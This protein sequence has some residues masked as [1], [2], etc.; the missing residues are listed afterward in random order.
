MRNVLAE[1][2]PRNDLLSE[3]KAAWARVAKVTGYIIAV[4]F[5]VQSVLYLLDVTGVLAAPIDYRVSSLGMQ[6]DLIIYY[7][8]L[9]ERM[10]SIWWSV[11]VR[12]TVGPLGY[13]SLIVLVLAISHVTRRGRP[14]VELALLFT[15]VGASTAAASD[16]IFLSQIGSWRYGFQ[17]TPD[18]VSFG[19]A[20]EILDNVVDYLQ[21][22]AFIVLA[23]AFVC[24]GGLI[25]SQR[26]SHRR[27]AQVFAYLEATALV[28]YV[29]ADLARWNTGQAVAA[30]MAGIVLGPTWAILVGHFLT[31]HG[32]P[33]VLGQ[34]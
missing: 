2:G 31:H 17:P 27:A 11:A 19:R 9:N 16:L 33:A 32:T 1:N 28:A 20:S 26:T 4:A 34:E 15:V 12:D 10:H 29:L 8:A 14:R 3:T 18:I 22:A 13:L 5:V 6:Q 25:T 21:Y 23:A 30:A 7:E 24:L